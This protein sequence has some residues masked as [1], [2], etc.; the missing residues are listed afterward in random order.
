MTAEEL[1]DRALNDTF[2]TGVSGSGGMVPDVARQQP[3]GP[4]FV[5]IS[6][7]LAF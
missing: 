3:R 4:Q 1:A 6:Q 2:Q 5:R 7:V